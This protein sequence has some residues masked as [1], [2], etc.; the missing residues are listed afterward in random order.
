MTNPVKS[1]CWRTSLGF[2]PRNLSEKDA[3]ALCET[4]QVVGVS[5][6]TD[7]DREEASRN[8]GDGP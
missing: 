1:V 8:S 6:F 3:L 2:W 7:A 4:M 5:E